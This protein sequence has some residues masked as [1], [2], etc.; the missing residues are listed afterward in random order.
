MPN[1]PE[2]KQAATPQNS[3]LPSETVHIQTPF[4]DRESNSLI[5]PVD[6][7][8]F[9]RLTS[10]LIKKGLE[11]QTVR[12]A[13]IFTAATGALA[14]TVLLAK[15]YSD[16]RKKSRETDTIPD[17]PVLTPSQEKAFTESY[18]ND[19]SEILAYLFLRGLDLQ[20]AQ[21]LTSETFTRLREK[22]TNYTVNP[23]F[24]YPY[25]PLLFRIAH[26]LHANWVRQRIRHP[27]SPLF[28]RDEDEIRE[29]S[30]IKKEK[31]P[32]EEII[33]ENEEKKIVGQAIKK[34]IPSYQEIIFLKSLM[35]EE[36]EGRSNE[37]V[38]EIL[39]ISVY[40]VK[41]RYHRACG[42]LAI[43]LKKIEI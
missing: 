25:R 17:P 12:N 11:P 40:A 33:E 20:D 4:I 22:F 29:R 5:L 42:R 13:V 2:L 21:N 34:L 30:D 37:A 27:D 32:V 24:Q 36:E 16:E 3:S 9:D 41:S 19:Y 7:N 31:R 15:R 38:S 43:E 35:A 1:S 6:S 26:N 14:G 8:V 18:Q 23:S 39:G 10:F 28:F